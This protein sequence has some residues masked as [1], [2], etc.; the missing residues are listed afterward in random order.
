MKQF[1]KYTLATIVGI[2]ISS[3]ILFFIG[4]LMLA[5]IAGSSISASKDKE[6]YVKPNTVLHLKLDYPVFDRGTDNPFENINWATFKPEPRLGL[7]EILRSIDKA[8][9][10]E[11]IKGIYLDLMF[12]P[13]GIA[14]LDEIRDA[15]LDFKESGKF[16]LSYGDLYVQST[17]YLASV[18]DR[19]YLNPQGIIDFKG[20]HS[21]LMFFKGTLEK[22][23]IEPIVIRGPENIY[24][25]AIEPFTQ[26]EMTPANEEQMEALIFTLWNN[27]LAGISESRKIPVE[28]L[29]TIADSVYV[30]SA[31]SAKKYKLADDLLYK[32]QFRD[33][34]LEFAGVEDIKD[35]N[36][37]KLHKYRYAPCAG[38]TENKPRD[39]KIAVIYAT[40]AI[41]FG[42]GDDQNIGSERFSKTLRKAREDSTIKA[43]VL[44]I[45]SPGGNGLASEIIWREVYLTTQEKPV[46][47]SMGSLAA[48]GGY[49]IACP[50]DKIICSPYTITGSIGVYGLLFNASEFLEQKLGITTDGISTNPF[51]DLGSFTRPMK[52]AER[53]IINSYVG[54][55]YDVFLDHVANGRDISKEQVDSIGR[56]RVW[57]GVDAKKIGLVDDFGGLKKSIDVAA[58]TAGLEEYRIVELPRRP[59]PFKMFFKGLS[60]GSTGKILEEKLGPG[61]KYYNYLYSTLNDQG[62]QARM[63]FIIE[64][65]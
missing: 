24:K 64:I 31:E 36:M 6:V 38:E 25:S 33:K 44:R 11:N 3:V 63:P 15:L 29:K 26:K 32:D 2:I 34:L 62:I 41:G 54:N 42:E 10:D 60:G 35:L 65:Y 8:K 1:L 55:V 4:V 5:G 12:V 13:A 59:D 7:N 56:G 48:S 52:P 61:F 19:V 20:L 39:K 14:A 53:E 57:S 46:I 37:M 9:N 50:A 47:V 16:V 21:E 17:Y 49:Y 27:M 28:E 22:L 51:A 18:S 58:E 45:N 30:R 23:G 40:G 43:V